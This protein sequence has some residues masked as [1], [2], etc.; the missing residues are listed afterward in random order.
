MYVQFAF[1]DTEDWSA[2][3]PV[4]DLTAGPY[5]GAFRLND[6]NGPAG[7]VAGTASLVQNGPVKRLVNKDGAVS[8]RWVMTPYLLKV[9]AEGPNASASVTCAFYQVEATMHVKT[10]KLDG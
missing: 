5:A 10:N 8:D 7:E 1:A 6:G 4:M 3:S 2:S 9:T